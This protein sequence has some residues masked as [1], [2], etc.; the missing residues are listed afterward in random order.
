MVTSTIPS[1]FTEEE[2]A[3]LLAFEAN[4][5]DKNLLQKRSEAYEQ[6]HLSIA[7]RIEEVAARSQI[8]LHRR[9]VRLQLV[10]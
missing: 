9:Y 2:L 8:R 10:H 4:E 1:K 3:F 7:L 6:Q 5:L